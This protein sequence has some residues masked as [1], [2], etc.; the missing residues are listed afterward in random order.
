MIR[1]L[2]T[3]YLAALFVGLLPTA[4]CN[5]NTPPSFEVVAQRQEQQRLQEQKERTVMVERLKAAAIADDKKQEPIKNLQKQ[6]DDLDVAIS[7]AWSQGKDTRAL[8]KA[9]DV[10]EEQKYDLERQ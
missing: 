6:I 9:E 3:L 2:D 1:R 4:G 10:L 7:D 8:E 5:K